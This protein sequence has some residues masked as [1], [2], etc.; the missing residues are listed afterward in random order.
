MSTRIERSIAAFGMGFIAFIVLG[1]SMSAFTDDQH[2]WGLVGLILTAVTIVAGYRLVTYGVG[3]TPT[4][5]VMRGILRTRAVN[6]TDIDGF[7]EAVFL[8][9]ITIVAHLTNGRAIR[10]PLWRTERQTKGRERL[11]AMLGEHVAAEM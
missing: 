5:L 4:E 11:L 2:A 10:L 7:S 6:W 1:E 3:L 9:E 8:G